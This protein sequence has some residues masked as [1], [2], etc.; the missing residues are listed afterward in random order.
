MLIFAAAVAVPWKIDWSFFNI[1]RIKMYWQQFIKNVYYIFHKAL[2]SVTKVRS[3]AIV[4]SGSIFEKKLPA[5]HWSTEEWT[6][7]PVKR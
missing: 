3:Y 1:N 6:V 5:K 2:S 7:D 4:H